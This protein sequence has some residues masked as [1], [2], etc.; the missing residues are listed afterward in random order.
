EAYGVSKEEAEKQ[1]ADWE[2]KQK[3]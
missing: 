3:D 2:Q 1:L